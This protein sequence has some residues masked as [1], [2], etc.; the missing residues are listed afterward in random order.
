M[1]ADGVGWRETAGSG[2]EEDGV[3]GCRPPEPGRKSKGR[4]SKAGRIAAKRHKRH[5]KEKIAKT[6]KG[7]G[8]G[9][10]NGEEGARHEE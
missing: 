8:K 1:G 3:F 9:S 6:A 10:V 7:R 2:F 4:R 5:R